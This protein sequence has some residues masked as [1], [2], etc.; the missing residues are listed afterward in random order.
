MQELN[1]GL[2]LLVGR[3]ELERTKQQRYRYATISNDKTGN[4]LVF[5]YETKHL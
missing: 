1:I 3:N 5:P 4:A 2:G